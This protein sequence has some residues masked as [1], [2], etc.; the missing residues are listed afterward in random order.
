MTM[1]REDVETKVIHVQTNSGFALDLILNGQGG[2]VGL[3]II[4]KTQRFQPRM[5]EFSNE[6]WHD[7]IDQSLHVWDDA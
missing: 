6:Q 3:Q 2:P 7:L 4:D 1:M 5:I